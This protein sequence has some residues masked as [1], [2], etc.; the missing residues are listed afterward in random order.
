MT[1]ESAEQCLIC[2]STDIR[3][4]EFDEIGVAKCRLEKH[5]NDRDA[6]LRR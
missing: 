1:G 4:V 2:R 5:Q 3:E 6:A